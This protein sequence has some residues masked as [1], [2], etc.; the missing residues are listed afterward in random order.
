MRFLTLLT[1]ATEINNAK[2]EKILSNFCYKSDEYTL[3]MGTTTFGQEVVNLQFIYKID[4]QEV[5]IYP[6]GSISQAVGL[7]KTCSPKVDCHILF[8]YLQINT[9]YFAN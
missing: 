9:I 8:V 7:Q 1:F 6:Q 4:F 2:L 5:L 3:N